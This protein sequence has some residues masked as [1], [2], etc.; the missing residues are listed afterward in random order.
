MKRE[1]KCLWRRGSFENAN[2]DDLPP[3]WNIMPGQFVLTSK[4]AYTA[5]AQQKAHVVAQGH[6]DSG[7]SINVHDSVVLSHLALRISLSYASKL[8]FEF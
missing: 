5:M 2:I 8:G 7:K 6:M 4:S 3:N 1:T